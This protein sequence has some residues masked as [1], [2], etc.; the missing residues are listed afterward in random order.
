VKDG[1][2]R[3][4]EEPIWPD[5]PICGRVALYKTASEFFPGRERAYCLRHARNLECDHPDVKLVRL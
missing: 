2:T 3:T 4:C 1:Q 5:G